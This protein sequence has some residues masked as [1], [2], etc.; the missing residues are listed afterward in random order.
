MLKIIHDETDTTINKMERLIIYTFYYQLIRISISVKI[1]F[2]TQRIA[3][4]K[5][6]N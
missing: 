4:E 2:I 5:F 3:L 1:K 6:I